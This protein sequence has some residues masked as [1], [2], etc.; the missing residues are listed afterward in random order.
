MMIE[1]LYLIS[2]VIAIFGYI[3]LGV[4][5]IMHLPMVIATLVIRKKS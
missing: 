3:F 1:D 5:T 2:D 4:M